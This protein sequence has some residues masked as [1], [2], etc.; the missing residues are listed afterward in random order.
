MLTK[1]IYFVHG[2]ATDN[3]QNLAPSPITKDWHKRRAWQAGRE[4]EVI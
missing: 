4:Y 2:T 1:I 3:E